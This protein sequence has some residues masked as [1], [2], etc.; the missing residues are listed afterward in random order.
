MVYTH[1]EL[2]THWTE[3]DWTVTDY[4]APRHWVEELRGLLN[5]R[6]VTTPPPPLDMTLE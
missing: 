5:M 4:N 1:I 6:M 2:V 3:W